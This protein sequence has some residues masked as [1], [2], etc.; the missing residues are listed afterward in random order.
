[1]GVEGHV[2]ISAHALCLQDEDSATEISLEKNNSESSMS[3]S[4]FG[5]SQADSFAT[6]PGQ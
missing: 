4:H 2:S 6:M 5:S 3:L 1:M